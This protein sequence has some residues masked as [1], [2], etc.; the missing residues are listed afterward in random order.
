LIGGA[1]TSRAHTAVKIA[2]AYG[3]PTVHVLD[4]SRVVGVVSDLMDPGR[5]REL[6]RQNREEQARLRV[7]HGRKRSAP[8][9]TYEQARVN[10]LK[11]EF[12][13]EQLA[14]PA[15]TGRR[16]L[17]AY[18]LA[19]IARFIDWT[20][21]FHAWELRGKFPD[22]LD[23]PERGQAARDLFADAK[24]M[25]AKIVDEKLLTANAV[26]GFWPAVSEGDTIVLY[27]DASTRREIA[28]FPMLRQQQK[29]D[30]GVA[31]RVSLADFIAPIESGRID[32]LGAFAVTAGIGVDAL[33]KKLE[34][35]NDDYS[36]IMVKALADRLA[37][38]FAE[39]LHQ[40]AR[41]DWGYGK[42]EQLSNE[43]LIDEKYRGIRPA[44]GYPACPD[45]LP[46]RTLFSL[47]DAGE[48]GLELTEHCAMTP[49]AAVSGLYFAHPNARYFAIGPVQ[50][51]QVIA[52]AQASDMPL[53][54][55]ER[56]LGPS[57]GYDPAAVVEAAE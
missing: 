50:R 10:R 26:Y 55:M 51:D 28:R 44:F 4:A 2:P 40:R 34:A 47:L 37:E 52:Y 15:F 11:L 38:A 3:R 17:S 36:A 20:F 39:L 53:A 13:P 1:T 57:L 31:P 35:Q 43:E 42:N 41:A 32:Y 18:P 14:V 27:D 21:F 23:H 8:S 45:H 33:V 48:A 25:L 22:L 46:K 30:D 6:D 12:G 5:R 54:D 19:E 29:P 9:Y 56:W 7:L 16:L 24:K 49:A